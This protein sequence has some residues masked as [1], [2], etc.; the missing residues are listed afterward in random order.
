MVSSRKFLRKRKSKTIRAISRR[1]DGETGARGA[2]FSFRAQLSCRRQVKNKRISRKNNPVTGNTR[3]DLILQ[4][5]KLFADFTG[6]EAQRGDIVKKPIVPDVL[7]RIGECDA[8]CYT[9]IRDGVR[10]RYIHE[11]SKS[12][13]PVFAVAPDGSAIF[14]IG[15]KYNFTERGIIDKR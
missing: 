10:E 4:A 1:H 3:L 5:Q 9:T 12:A 6:E 7:T 11:F 14:L 15:G 8:I 2:C 13:R